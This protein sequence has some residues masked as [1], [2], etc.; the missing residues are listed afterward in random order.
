MNH[1]IGRITAVV[2]VMFGALFVNLNIITLLQADDLANHPAN[3]RLIVREYNIARGPIVVGE[4]AVAISTPTDGELRY[5]REYPQG[6]LY[7]HLTGYY[8]MVLQRSGLE[9]A[10]NEQLTG[11]PTEVVAQNLGDLLGSRGR[12]GNA[13]VLTIDPHVQAAAEAALEGREGA[14]VVIDT[15]TGAVVASYANPTFDPNPLSSHDPG[16]VDVAWSQL[17]SRDDSPL[18]DRTR[19]ELYP[20][21][22]VFKLVVTAAAL[23]HGMIPTQLVPDETVFDVPQ[24][25]AN[26]GNY[27][28]GPCG[29][30]TTI[31]L[32][33]ALRV[34]CNTVFARIGVQLGA[35]VLAE[36]AAKLGFNHAIPFEL[37]TVASV[38]P[39]EL[40]IPA[41]AQSAIGQRDVRAT[42]LHM[43]LIAAAIVNEGE[44]RQ[45]HVVAAVY[46][47]EGRQVRGPD[48]G[49][50][51][52]PPGDGRAMS[53]R[54]AQQLRRMM[55]Q[56]VNAGTGTRAAIE[57]V[58]VGG[59]T[60]TAQTG[61]ASRPVAWFVG[62]ADN[63][64]AIAVAVAGTSP[65]DTGGSVAA[66]L[67]RQV[68]QA[69]LTSRDG[70]WPNQ[71]AVVTT[72]PTTEGAP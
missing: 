40:D 31:S 60:G 52:G 28:G 56:A 23:E 43:A 20:P 72:D 70:G 14:V 48:T 37:A 21:G 66:P 51:Q 62:F 4:N 65:R 35:E 27:G 38:F 57:G 33:D 36:Q 71:P 13:V 50:W 19:R 6:P 61:D 5:L 29:G 15:H 3:R 63:D 53:A 26:I 45:P 46:D 18:I 30:G 42:P 67:A 9:A 32:E 8:S 22:S 49:R 7:A 41:T 44:L 2:L 47:P 34:S 55:I 59:K 64:L 25:T 10:L 39:D 12:P 69:A 11:Q 54:T 68:L 1:T 16:D 17:L 24:T 58:Q